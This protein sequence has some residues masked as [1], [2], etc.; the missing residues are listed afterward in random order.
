[1]G[2]LYNHIQCHPPQA[3]LGPRVAREEG[4]LHHLWQV[5]KGEDWPVQIREVPLENRALRG[6]ELGPGHRLPMLSTLVERSY[7]REFSHAL[8]RDMELLHFGSAGRGMLVFPTSK[9]PFYQWEAFGL[10]GAV[11]PLMAS[12]VPRV[13]CVA[14]GHSVSG[15]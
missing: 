12:G 8:G 11:E 1:M 2:A 14:S 10:A 7:S 4:A 5:A 6:A 15:S 9:R 13:V 3:L